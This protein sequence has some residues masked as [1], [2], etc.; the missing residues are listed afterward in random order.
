MKVAFVLPGRGR[1]G[2]VRVTVKMGNELRRRGHDVRL[3]WRRM[4]FPSK[5][6]VRF[7]LVGISERAGLC[8]DRDWLDEFQGE[9]VPYTCLS[10]IAFA[11]NEV[12]I[13]V[14]AMTVMDLHAL[15]APVIKV[16][17]NHGFSTCRPEL[18]RNAWGVPMPTLTVSNTL[19]PELERLSGCPV[20][21]VI[22]NGIELDKYYDMGLG[23]DGVGMVFSGHPNKRPQD[24]LALLGRIRHDWPKVPQYVFGEPRRPNEI[25][26]GSYW[27]F[28]SVAQACELY[29]RSRVW[30]LTS[31]D[32]GLPGPVLEAMACG[33]AVVSTENLGSREIIEHGRNGLLAPIGDIDGMTKWVE[34]LLTDEGRRMELVE[35]GFRTVKRHTWDGAATKMEQALAKLV[36]ECQTGHGRVVAS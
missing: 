15:Q 30:V 12:V 8:R 3:L 18:M 23:R 22:P 26:K 16:R 10:E 20:H 34:L 4:P 1:S 31:Q 17:Y 36:E 11:P 13:A 25:P 33:A 28:P 2:G 7:T 5:T 6:W 19:V 32:E 29:N 9:S 14:G 24:A 35:Q 21:A 27:R